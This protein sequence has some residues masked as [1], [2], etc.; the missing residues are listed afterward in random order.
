LGAIERIER[1]GG[2]MGQPG[3]KGADAGIQRGSAGLVI[4]VKELVCHGEFL[5]WS[6]GFA[7]GDGG[8]LAALRGV[9]DQRDA[10]PGDGRRGGDG[11]AILDEHPRIE[12][13]SHAFLLLA[14]GGGVRAI[15]RTRKKLGFGSAEIQ[16]K[17][18]QTP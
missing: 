7:G 12:W 18:R 5:S 14:I 11:G 2:G 16:S 1:G 10:E 4:A 13:I 3:G 15:H 8:G 9:V 17:D 6:G